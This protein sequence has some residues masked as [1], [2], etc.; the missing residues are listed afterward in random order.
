MWFS[1]VDSILRVLLVGPLAYVLMVAAIRLS[2]KRVL[3]KLNAFDMVVTVA[4]GS[5]LATILTSADLS[6]ATG[7]TGIVLLLVLQVAVTL[8]TSRFV[9]GET[10]VRARPTLLVRHGVA[11]R[12]AIE[13]SRLTD[14]EV[15]QAIRSKGFGGLD[16]IAA[17]CL[18]SDG[19]LSVVGASSLGD[20]RALHDVSG[21][22]GARS[23]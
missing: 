17:V 8:I 14:A 4:M 2:G 7:L 11:L 9:Q 10:V 18:E 3:S 16:E 6:L 1:S 5:L 22:N 15:L 13:S 20:A 12:E 21:W 23:G 19:T